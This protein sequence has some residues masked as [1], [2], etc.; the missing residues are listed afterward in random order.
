M[1]LNQKLDSEKLNKLQEVTKDAPIYCIPVDLTKDGTFA[2]EAYV[3]ATQSGIFLFED[4][5]FNY[6][7][8]EKIEKAYNRVQTNGSL[9]T[10]LMGGEEILLARCSMRYASG[11]ASL[12][13]GINILLK[14]NTERRIVNNEREKRCRKCGRVLP[15]TIACPKCDKSVGN[16]KRFLDICAQNKVTLTI[17]II[18]MLIDAFI[19][20]SKEYIL[21]FFVDQHL[22]TGSGTV[23]D[24][25][26]FFAIYLGVILFGLVIFY[27]K[28]FFCGKMGVRVVHQLRKKLSEHL[29]KMSLS[30]LNTR[31]AGEIVERV[32]GDTSRV[33]W[34][35]NGAFCSIFNQIFYIIG[36]VTIMLIMNWKLALL[37]F[38]FIPLVLVFTK[39][40]WPKIHRIF[41]NLWRKMDGVQNKLQDVLSGIRIVKTYGREESEIN[42]FCKAN[43]KHAVLNYKNE[44]FFAIF[45]PIITL[46]FSFST[47][48]VIYA[49]GLDVLKGNMTPGELMQFVAYT[50]MLLGPLHSMTYL[51]REI[52]TMTTSLERI[53]DVLGE[54][55][56]IKSKENAIEREIEGNI[57]FEDVVFGYHTHQPV[58]DG[59]TLDVK[60]GEMIGLVGP[61]GA[62]KST[63]INLVMRL[64]DVDEGTVFV[65]GIDIKDYN[66]ECYHSQIGV[67]LQET[68]LFAGSVVDNIKFANPKASMSEIISAAKAANAH[69]FICKLPDGYNTYVGE[70]GHNLSGGEKQRIAIARAILNNPKILILDE[71]TSALD[72]ESE[73][74]VQQAL[75]RLRKNRTT[76]AIAH[77]LST[78]RQADRIAVIDDRKIAEVGTHNE[79]LKNKGIYYNLVMAQLQMNKTADKM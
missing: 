26:M 45:Y 47:Y 59:V 30:N 71:A 77:R 75:E 9:F 68:F 76:F 62:G 7:P 15:G 34:F 11:I 33:R 79:L 61:S 13:R 31:D 36:V 19:G 6:Y 48:I 12:A 53:Y 37:T 65:D 41:S 5:N 21:R 58:L 52:V 69:D 3:G 16:I 2:T 29:Q 8:F 78:L 49:G 56:A 66:T 18:F 10:V 44:K 70:K 64:Y 25:L 72:T 24:I 55:P 14:G 1:E 74:Q 35:F 51:P 23:F 22:I 57:K 38:L 28:G 63:L 43:K 32:M 17:I 60:A 40:F 67:V 50:G 54:E 20:I 46:I 4:N 39:T 42:E 73:Y 27:I